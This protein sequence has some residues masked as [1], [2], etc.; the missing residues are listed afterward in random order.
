MTANAL[1]LRINTILFLTTIL[2][3]WLILE[4]P[5]KDVRQTHG[6]KGGLMSETPANPSTHYSRHHMHTTE[7]Q[8]VSPVS[9]LQL[10]KDAN[11]DNSAIASGHAAHNARKA[12]DNAKV[13]EAC[14]RRCFET[15]L[16]LSSRKHVDDFL[17]KEA[18]P[19]IYQARHPRAVLPPRRR[20]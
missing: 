4:G 5:A 9:Q 17:V 6:Y 19:K 3:L 16:R 20:Q 14:T 18:K 7:D 2:F 12:I 15:S 13:L 8:S 1:D 10:R 11:H